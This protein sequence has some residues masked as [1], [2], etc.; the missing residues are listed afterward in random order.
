MKR[1]AVVTPSG[2]NTPV[3]CVLITAAGTANAEMVVNFPTEFLSAGCT[4][5]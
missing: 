2:F 1:P 4:L 3:R 5:Q